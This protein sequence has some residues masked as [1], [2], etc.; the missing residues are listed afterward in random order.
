[1]ETKIIKDVFSVAINEDNNNIP[2]WSIVS[3]INSMLKKA[4]IN[5]TFEVS[6]QNK[7]NHNEKGEGTL[8]RLIAND[9]EWRK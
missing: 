7:F 8:L 4:G 5:A 3:N 2:T 1:M 6:Q 9:C